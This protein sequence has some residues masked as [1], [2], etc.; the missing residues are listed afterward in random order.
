M[1]SESIFESIIRPPYLDDAGI[2]TDFASKEALL[3]AIFGGRYEQLVTL[4]ES[5]L[6]PSRGGIEAFDE[7]IKDWLRTIPTLIRVIVELRS[8]LWTGT[9]TPTDNDSIGAELGIS[10]VAVRALYDE[11]PRLLAK[12]DA[13]QVLEPR[14]AS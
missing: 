7:R 8:G 6:L 1:T 11:G 5:A 3:K 13:V 10:P 9:A 12:S 4:N 2:C 14:L